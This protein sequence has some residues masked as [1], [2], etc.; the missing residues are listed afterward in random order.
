MRKPS[1]QE[2]YWVEGIF[3]RRVDY[4]TSCETYLLDTG[5][6]SGVGLAEIFLTGTSNRHNFNIRIS[7][8]SI[9]VQSLTCSFRQ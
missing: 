9:Q 6:V 3:C 1:I 8:E 5:K 7:I 4:I 2:K